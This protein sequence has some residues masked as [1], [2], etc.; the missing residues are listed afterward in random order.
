MNWY[1][2]CGS[3]PLNCV[4]PIGRKHYKFK[5]L[6][7]AHEKAIDGKLTFAIQE[8][9]GRIVDVIG[10]DDIDAWCKWAPGYFASLDD[11]V[12][13]NQVG[14]ELSRHFSSG[15]FDP[16]YYDQ[17]WFFWRLQAML[18]L[19]T[20]ISNIRTIEEGIADGNNVN[21]VLNNIWMGKFTYNYYKTGKNG[22]NLYWHPTWDGRNEE[23]NSSYP[24][25]HPLVGLA[26]E[27]SHGADYA[28]DGKMR[29]SKKEREKWAIICENQARGQI[30]TKVPGWEDM[31]FRYN[32][33]FPGSP[34]WN[35][36]Y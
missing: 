25:F 24:K 20:G 30:K 15:P 36:D 19:G 16:D 6:G 14:Y 8:D 1:N 32:P 7:Y 10:F 11:W 18:F 28:Y 9:D 29:K 26:H 2:Y 21:V 22:I 5:F 34:G 13:E 4:D 27:L 12:K 35:H 33:Y 23:H 31:Q 17:D 3:N